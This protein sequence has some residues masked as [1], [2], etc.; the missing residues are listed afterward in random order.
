MLAALT[1]E[2]QYLTVPFRSKPTGSYS[3]R[4]PTLSAPHVNTPQKKKKRLISKQ[5]TTLIHPKLLS[6]TKPC[7]WSSLAHNDAIQSCN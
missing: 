4:L 1:E 3:E 2:T 6:R 5:Q 7:M